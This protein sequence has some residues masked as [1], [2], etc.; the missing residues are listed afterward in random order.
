[1]SCTSTGSARRRSL[2]YL[3]LPLP[4]TQEHWW[5][6]VWRPASLPAVTRQSSALMVCSA[7]CAR[8]ARSST[9]VGGVI[10]TAACRA[11]TIGS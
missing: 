9:Y 6:S 10:R 1:M 2:M 8:A 11:K 7:P 4:S 3:A 5:L